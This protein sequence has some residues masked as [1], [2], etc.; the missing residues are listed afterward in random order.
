[1]HRAHR[2]TSAAPGVDGRLTW[3]FREPVATL[4]EGGRT[5]GRHYAGPS[6]EWPRGEPLSSGVSPSA[7]RARALAA[8]RGFGWRWRN[9][10]GRDRGGRLGLVTVILRVNT[11]GGVVEGTCPTVGE[12]RAVPYAADYVFLT[13]AIRN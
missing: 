10:A 6:W 5:V 3:V 11:A 1:M 8:S 9:S 13:P 7:C 2:S 4:L 12:L